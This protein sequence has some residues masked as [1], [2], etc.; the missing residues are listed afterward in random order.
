MS[1]SSGDAPRRGAHPAIVLA[2]LVVAFVWLA[3]AGLFVFVGTRPNAELEGLLAMVGVVLAVPGAAFAVGAV[4]CS[5]AGARH[6]RRAVR[7]SL[8]LGVVE[9]VAAVLLGWEAVSA[10][11]TSGSFAPW[12][13]PLAAPALLL[14]GLGVTAVVRDARALRAASAPTS[15]S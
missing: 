4:A 8:A 10:T 14:A 15:D 11:T 13:S 3:F 2:H 7:L 5:L 12:R 6:P 1:T 9:I